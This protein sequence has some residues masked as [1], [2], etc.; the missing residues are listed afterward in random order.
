MT[1]KISTEKQSAKRKN[2]KKGCKQGGHLVKER[3]EKKIKTRKMGKIKKTNTKKAK[4]RKSKETSAKT[5]N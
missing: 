5:L 1:P 3:F 4:S 2:R